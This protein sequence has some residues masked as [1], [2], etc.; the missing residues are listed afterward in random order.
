MAL[1]TGTSGDDSL[2]GGAGN[3]SVTGLAGDDTLDG[4]AGRDT[5]VGG[6]GNDIYFVDLIHPTATTTALED[7][8]VEGLNAGFD[9]TL[10]VRAAGDFTLLAPFTVLLGAN[11][12]HLDLTATGTLDLR[13]TGNSLDNVI[14]GNAGDNILTGGLGADVLIGGAGNDSYVVDRAE[15]LTLLVENAGDS[16]D[17]V[18]VLYTTFLPQTIELAGVLAEIE[19]ITVLGGGL[20]NL[21]GNAAANILIGNAAANVLDGAG[22]ADLMTGGAGNDTFVVDN[23]GDQVADSSGIDTV[24]SSITYSLGPTIEKLTLTGSGDIDGTG[25]ALAN[26]LTGN[27]GINVLTGLGGSDTYIVQNTG[28]VVVEAAAAGTD[29]VV[30]SASYTLSANLE[31]LTLAPLAGDIDGTGNAGA[32]LITGNAGANVLDGTGG[33]DTLLGGQSNDTYRVDLIRPLSTTMLEDV[34]TEGLNAGTDTLELRAAGDF[35]LVSPFTAILGANFEN[36]DL[37]AT[38]TLAIGA[39]GNSLANTITGNAGDNTLA[40]GAGNDVLIGGAG[41]DTY[42]VDKAVE[43]GLLV[44]NAAEGSGDKVVVMFATLTPQAIELTGALA[45]I[46]HLAVL[47][48]GAFNLTGNAAAN[49]LAGNASANRIDGAGGADLMLGGGG[50]DTYVVDDT[51]DLIA[52][53]SGIDT[54]EASV[55]YSLI[56]TAP[57]VEKLTLTGSGDIDGTGNALAN[58]ITGN[59]GLNTLA[60]LGGNDI[61]VVH[62]TLD[63]VVELAAAGTDTVITFTDYTLGDHVEFLVLGPMPPEL[64]DIDGFGNAL[65]NVI[66]GNA[67]DNVLDG[68]AGK[69]LLK[70]GAGNDTYRVDLIRPFSTTMLEDVVTEGLNAGTDTLELRAG[71]GFT[72]VSPFTAILGANLENL[73]LTATGTLA[74]GALGNSL[75]NTITGNAGDNTLNGGLGIDV[76]I[77]GDGD[78]VYIVDRADELALLEENAAEGTDTL[79]VLFAT[80]TPQEIELTGALAEI[81]NLTVIGGGAY[82]LIGNVAGNVLIGNASA[83]VL[84]GAAGAD[85]M[86]GGLGN[87]TFIVDDAG[88]Q[89]SDSSGVDTVE[90]GVDYSLATFTTIEKL[91]LTGSGDIDGTGN[92]LANTITGNSGINTLAGLGGSDTYFVQNTDD[93]VVEALNGGTDVVRSSASLF[94]L[95]DNVEALVLVSGAGDID[96]IGNALANTITGNSGNNM[97]DGGGGRDVLVGGAG[98]DTYRVDLVRVSGVTMLQDVVTEGGLGGGNDTLMVRAAPELALPTPYTVVLATNLENLN[99]SLTGD[100]ANLNAT[101]NAAANVITGNNAANLITGLGGADLLSGAGGNDSFVWDPLDAGIDGGDGTDTLLV[102][103]ANVSINLAAAPQITHVEVIDLT[104]TGNNTLTLTDEDVLAASD[105][106]LRVD[107]NLGDVVQRGAGW[108]LGE[109]QVIGANTYRTYTQDGATLLV[110][111]DVS[112]FGPP[113]IPVGDSAAAAITGN[114]KIDGLLQGSS[115]EFPDARVI[116]YSLNSNLEPGFPVRSW[117]TALTTA[118]DRAFE[119]WESVLDVDFQRVQSGKYYFESQ[120]DFS[121]NVAG[122]ELGFLAGIGIFPDPVAADELLAGIGETREDYPRPEGDIAFNLTALH[123]EGITLVPIF[124]RLNPGDVG[125]YVMLHEIGHALGLKHTYDDGANGRLTFSELGIGGFDLLQYTVMGEEFHAGPQFPASPMS[126]DIQALQHLYGA[127]DAYKSGDDLYLLNAPML[128]GMRPGSHFTIWDSGGTDTLSAAGLTTGSV[129]DL[130]PGQQFTTAS[131]LGPG[132]VSIAFNVVIENAVG[133]SGVDIL[134]G[135]AVAN[136]LSGEDGNDSMFGEQGNDIIAGGAGNDTADGGGGTDAIDGGIGDDVLF[137]GEDNDVIVGGEGNDSLSAASASF[138]PGGHGNDSL[139]GGLGDDTLSGGSGNDTL[140]G[141]DGDDVAFGADGADV[142]SGGAG[143]DHLAG[144]DGNDVLDGGAGNDT[145]TA[146][147]GFDFS[148][149]TSTGG[150]GADEFVVRW[151]FSNPANVITDFT[152]D[153]DLLSLG[154]FQDQLF[155]QSAPGF[156]TDTL[157]E[158]VLVSAAAAS[159]PAH[160]LVYDGATG[161]LYYDHDGS[162]ATSA[163]HHIL[164]I[165]T[166]LTLDEADFVAFTV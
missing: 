163:P 111:T 148:I 103:G 135:N 127:N 73:D 109:D 64:D 69:D 116:T 108:S 122:S 144:A 96:G 54:A 153:E 62:N 67:G 131:T 141:G 2:L 78:D 13:A 29:A 113:A 166:G 8:V 35:T 71:G 118:I 24:E 112:V 151:Q 145:I 159:D 31:L 142:M 134:T 19:H 51:N 3:D 60:G 25:N 132:T 52:D 124:S 10:A 32:N 21:T 98:D 50:N 110:D 85:S 138:T 149:D 123:F 125:Y 49:T 20:F 80:L 30:A 83:N 26:V 5:L 146:A 158:G 63:E 66:T 16:A 155:E 39:L 117:T 59:S 70:G 165:G 164:T 162:G 104:G 91:T 33:R 157:L 126:L 28:D 114:A 1:V 23:P 72:L 90:A 152:P 7:V 107:G 14:T 4:G 82:T 47:G 22:G 97:L 119:A 41:N 48:A 101:G 75:A 40:G 84:D 154:S 133:G 95:G 15:E 11:L 115:W 56:V 140:I 77:G 136:E 147:G 18:V 128:P 160:R 27:S 150:P 43:L 79:R 9:D 76:L 89:V 120:A 99:L 42:I 105:G 86:S 34:V 46:E 137:G 58:V 130:R 93:V 94:A 92:A 74:I 57:L 68:A 139:D 106:T 17:A 45:E 88:D 61:Y 36:L 53:T 38:G 102:K 161:S 87:D 100:V 44:E 12:E 81:E 6:L 121:V 156:F 65:A 37:T 55:T 143:N 129:I